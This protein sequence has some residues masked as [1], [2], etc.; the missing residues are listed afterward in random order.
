MV[1]WEEELLQNILT[2]L[3]FIYSMNEF[4]RAFHK[5]VRYSDPQQ[6]RKPVACPSARLW[7]QENLYVK[8]VATVLIFTE[9]SEGWKVVILWCAGSKAKSEKGS[10]GSRRCF[11]FLASAGYSNLF[12]FISQR[13]QLP[14]KKSQAGVVFLATCTQIWPQSMNELDE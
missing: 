12:T 13:S 10:F 1:F 11:F 4:K 5:S 3:S 2:L 9:R 14:E 7:V 6:V 8:E